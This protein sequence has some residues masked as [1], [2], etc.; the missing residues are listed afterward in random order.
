LAPTPAQAFRPAAAATANTTARCR[1]VAE[2]R[3]RARV[4]TRTASARSIRESCPLKLVRWRRRSPRS[5]PY[6]RR[7]TGTCPAS[8]ASGQVA[9]S[10][11]Q[12][13]TKSAG[14][15]LF[16]SSANV[17]SIT[18]CVIP[19][20]SSS[21]TQDVC[22]RFQREG[23]NDRPQR[24]VRVRCPAWRLLLHCS[25]WAL[26]APNGNS[27]ARIR[28]VDVSSSSKPAQI[29]PRFTTRG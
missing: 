4:S 14:L 7:T 3:N 18:P 8:D 24:L 11:A 12:E 20:R 2:T 27:H 23:D 17:L 25:P 1:S 16:R 28:F 5:L 22:S 26:L 19:G 15:P 21:L 13:L 9:V 6:S 29:S 10:C